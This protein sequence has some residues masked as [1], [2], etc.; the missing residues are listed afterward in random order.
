MNV[1]NILLAMEELERWQKRKST[2]QR[3]LVGLETEV[4]RGVLNELKKV[5]TQIGYYK[6][7]IHDMK[8]KVSPP[9][10]L[11]LARK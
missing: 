7:L 10:M 3:D 6:D 2:L 9:S 4:K 11:D 8:M 1:Q 5:N